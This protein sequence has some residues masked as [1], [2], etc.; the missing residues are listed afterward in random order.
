MGGRDD[1]H[2]LL[3]GLHRQALLTLSRACGTKQQ[4][5]SVAGR[6]LSLCTRWKR[7]LRELDS[8]LGHVEKVSPQSCQQWVYE[9]ELEI[10]R[11]LGAVPPPPATQPPILAG[12][13]LEQPQQQDQQVVNIGFDES[14][15]GDSCNDGELD[16]DF[17][18]GEDLGSACLFDTIFYEPTDVSTNSGNQTD[19]TLLSCIEPCMTVVDECVS[20]E[21]RT[22]VHLDTSMWNEDP[23]CACLLHTIRYEP[24]DSVVDNEDRSNAVPPPFDDVATVVKEGVSQSSQTGIHFD[25]DV[26]IAAIV[27]SEPL[28]MAISCIDSLQQHHIR[29]HDYLR[30]NALPAIS[31]EHSSNADVLGSTEYISCY[32]TVELNASFLGAMD[33]CSQ[34]AGKVL[35]NLVHHRMLRCAVVLWSEFVYLSTCDSSRNQH[36]ISRVWHAWKALMQIS[37]RTYK[38]ALTDAPSTKT[39]SGLVLCSS[40]ASGICSCDKCNR[41]LDI[42]RSIVFGTSPKRCTCE[43]QLAV[44][45]AAPGHGFAHSATNHWV[46]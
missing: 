8:T 38:Q 45:R 15:S 30:S 10:S 29:C 26:D 4:G 28:S 23:A 18:L 19:A 44:C 13:S 11:V 14:A 12:E 1:P 41:A 42:A 6:H 27:K 32:D 33:I 40:C 36:R 3:A 34:A 24:T 46:A 2:L 31:I 5:L 21:L 16:P 17:L 9:L 20:H 37:P 7:K 39:A 43:G 22:G 25:T 35:E